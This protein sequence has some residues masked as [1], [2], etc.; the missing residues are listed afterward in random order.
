MA[1]RAL[2]GSF[3]CVDSSKSATALPAN[4][5]NVFQ[6]ASAASSIRN[7]VRP[8]FWNLCTGHN[9]D[10]VLGS[11]VSTCEAVLDHSRDQHPVRYLSELFDHKHG[12]SCLHRNTPDCHTMSYAEHVSNDKQER[13]LLVSFG[14]HTHCYRSYC[15]QVSW[16]FL[17]PIPLKHSLMTLLRF[18]NLAY[19]LSNL[20]QM[21]Y[22]AEVTVAMAVGNA[23]G[24][25]NYITKRFGLPSIFD[26]GQT[27]RVHVDISPT[28]R[29]LLASSATPGSSNLPSSMWTRTLDLASSA[30]A[31]TLD[32]AS[33]TWARTLDFAS[34]IRARILAFTREKF[35]ILRGIVHSRSD[36]EA[37]VG[38]TTDLGIA[39][40]GGQADASNDSDGTR[41]A[42]S[43]PQDASAGQSTSS[44]SNNVATRLSNYRR[45]A[46]RT[47]LGRNRQNNAA[48]ASTKKVG[49]DG[50]PDERGCLRIGEPRELGW[51][52]NPSWY[53]RTCVSA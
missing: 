32:F 13:L 45:T 35:N 28:H 14:R 48:K 5:S 25:Y 47:M 11:L 20:Y 3:K 2:F 52:I 34:S 18:W 30:W 46:F 21:G 43:S 8:R 19:P 22:L 31:R 36:E 23:F 51:A 39:A 16:D 53:A 4:S 26:L 7:E 37:G 12:T 50:L 17:H 9:R 6:Q 33:S 41:T 42:S 40:A 10:F 44:S 27:P 29:T 15:K 38:P 24:T 49:P 1:S